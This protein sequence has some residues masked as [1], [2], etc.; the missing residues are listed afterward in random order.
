[1][2]LTISRRS[3]NPLTRSSIT[4][5][6]NS[7]N[8]QNRISLTTPSHSP[9]PQT[10]DS[11]I[12][13]PPNP[14]LDPSKVKL[15]YKRRKRR[16]RLSEISTP[17]VIYILSLTIN[18][19]FEIVGFPYITLI[20]QIKAF[21]SK[22][23]NSNNLGPSI[24]RQISKVHVKSGF[25]NSGNTGKIVILSQIVNAFTN[26]T[27]FVDS[28]NAFYQILYFTLFSLYALLIASF[29]NI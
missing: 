3:L 25:A 11:L 10:R 27:I 23:K 9:N 14:T 2:F 4:T 18:G 17:I 20:G 28:V 15:I 26:S 13:P 29:Y 1:M 7:P 21:P 5:P 24:H 16:S 19:D 8:P 12:I 22:L 6:S